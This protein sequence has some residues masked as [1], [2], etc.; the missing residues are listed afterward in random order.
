MQIFSSF[1]S[2]SYSSSSSSAYTHDL[3]Y[4]ITYTHTRIHTYIHTYIAFKLDEDEDNINDLV[5]IGCPKAV[6]HN[7]LPLIDFLN[8]SGPDKCDDSFMPYEYMLKFKEM[9]CAVKHKVSIKSY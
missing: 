3:Y 1:S 5:T 9:S 2:S 6:V 8:L 7:L 4:Y